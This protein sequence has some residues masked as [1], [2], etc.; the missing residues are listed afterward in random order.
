MR[1]RWLLNAFAAAGAVAV[2]SLAVLGVRGVLAPSAGSKEAVFINTPGLF[3]HPNYSRAAKISGFDDLILIA[4]QTAS[5]ENYDCVAPGD[6]RMQYA[7]ILDN[8]EKTLAAVGASFTDVVYQRVFVRDIDA[9]FD[10]L[11]AGP[12]LRRFDPDRMPPAT[13]I[14]VT[15]LSDPC[16]LIEVDMVAVK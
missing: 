11:A 8:L 13:L 1:W 3:E 2:V 4:G 16:F 10:A 15:R 9:Y 6:Y 14:G 5:D 7:H 12:S